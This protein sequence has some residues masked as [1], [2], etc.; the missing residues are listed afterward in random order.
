MLFVLL[1]LLSFAAAEGDWFS[2]CT[3]TGDVATYCKKSADEN[4]RGGTYSCL[5]EQYNMEPSPLTKDCKE[6]MRERAERAKTEAQDEAEKNDWANIC[7]SDIDKVCD[8]DEDIII[9]EDAESVIRGEQWKCLA[10][11]YKGD[12]SKLGPNCV[13]AIEARSSRAH[14]N[15]L[16]RCRTDLEA[17]CSHVEDESEIF[18]CLAA[19]VEADATSITEQC[20]DSLEDLWEQMCLPDLNEKCPDELNS[21]DAGQI[22]CLMKH[23]EE[24]LSNSCLSTLKVLFHVLSAKNPGAVPR[25]VPAQPIGIPST[26]TTTPGPKPL[27][28]GPPAGFKPARPQAPVPV[29]EKQCPRLARFPVKK[30]PKKVRLG[31]GLNAKGFCKPLR[32]CRFQR[33]FAQKNFFRTRKACRKAR[34]GCNKKN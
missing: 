27:P 5:A 15:W 28:V 21:D 19:K 32:G 33:K 25:P 26:E 18:P 13:A 29:G 8:I 12:K 3:L 7:S 4:D 24:G 17:T 31:W 20:S 2:I 11:T 23:S 9:Q 30:C 16:A 6:K 14:T 10:T 22:Q 34:R 1:G